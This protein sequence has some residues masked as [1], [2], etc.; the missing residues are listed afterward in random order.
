[1]SE[2]W[3]SCHVL[4]DYE[5]LGGDRVAERISRGTD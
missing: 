4:L 1:M 2:S 5:I 3:R